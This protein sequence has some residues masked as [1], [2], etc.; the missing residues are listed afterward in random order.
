MD[1]SGRVEIAGRIYQ[2]PKAAIQE[3]VDMIGTYP[4]EPSPQL[5]EFEEMKLI[6]AKIDPKVWKKAAKEAGVA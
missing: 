1:K 3:F 6:K 2:G 5:A 4:S